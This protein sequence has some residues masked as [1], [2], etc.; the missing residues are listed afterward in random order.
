M[1]KVLYI[2]VPLALVA[3]V[4]IKLKSN[5]NTAEDRVYHYDK[6]KAIHVNVETI[7]MELI[8][9]DFLYSG[10]FEPYKETKLSA[11]IQGKIND[12]LVDIGSTVVKGQP[13]IQL[14][15]SLLKP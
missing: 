12:V 8:G 15:N 13:L 9:A 1:K 2:I 11:E 14:D 5:K 4:V 3:I 7:K 6:E 10:T